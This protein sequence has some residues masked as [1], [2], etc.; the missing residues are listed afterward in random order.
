MTYY[1]LCK[2]YK[3]TYLWH[4]TEKFCL[5]KFFFQLVAFKPLL[6]LQAFVLL[7]L[8][9]HWPL[10]NDERLR[11]NRPNMQAQQG[12]SL[13]ISIN[14]LVNEAT[15]KKMSPNKMFSF[16]QKICRPLFHRYIDQFDVD[17]I[18]WVI[19]KNIKVVSS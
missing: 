5:L 11:K 2:V 8:L 16:M 9:L 10:T 18:N 3:D 17:S 1:L 7:T 13:I 4:N 6:R 15:W 14:Y 12:Q 19:K